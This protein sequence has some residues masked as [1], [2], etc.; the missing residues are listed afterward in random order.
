VWPSSVTTSENIG[1]AMITLA[2]NAPDLP[3]RVLRSD[4]I[5]ELAQA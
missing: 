5:N 2:A 1:R 3:G 4:K